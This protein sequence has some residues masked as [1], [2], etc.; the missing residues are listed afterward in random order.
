MYGS[1][2]ALT[3]K[4]VFKQELSCVMQSCLIF[5]NFFRL[6]NKY[7]QPYILL[8]T[9]KRI[10]KRISKCREV[11]TTTSLVKLLSYI[12]VNS[13]I[14]S[15]CFFIN[16]ITYLLLVYILRNNDDHLQYMRGIFFILVRSCRC[17]DLTSCHLLQDPVARQCSRQL[18]K[19]W[20]KLMVKPCF[21]ARNTFFALHGMCM[22]NWYE[23]RV[24]FLLCWLSKETI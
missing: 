3:L 6:Y 18:L 10:C 20:L 22:P 15:A 5:A 24:L 2:D 23:F 7:M 11:T 8:H 9:I 13:R 1:R 21:N 16:I 12:I 17:P 19:N 4:L 14:I